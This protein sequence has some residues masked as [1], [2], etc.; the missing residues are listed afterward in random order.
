MS[1]K[2]LYRV[3]KMGS[4]DLLLVISES[5]VEAARSMRRLCG[6]TPEHAYRVWPLAEDIGD[7]IWLTRIDLQRDRELVIRGPM[8]AMEAGDGVPSL[9]GPH[10]E[11][12][13]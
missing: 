3:L 13:V 1:D 7:G 5:P 8:F 2:R 10:T 4:P 11:V 9:W 12:F 6:D